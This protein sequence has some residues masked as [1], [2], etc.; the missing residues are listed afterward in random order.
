MSGSRW[1]LALVLSTALSENAFGLEVDPTDAAA[2]RKIAYE[3]QAAY[4]A[5]D[6][7]AAR[8]RASVA[9]R[10]V[11]VPTLALLEGRALLRLD[12][13]LE[14]RECFRAAAAP[15]GGDAPAA[16]ERAR[17]EAKQALGK[18]ERDLPRIVLAIEPASTLP[19][20]IALRLDGQQVSASLLG[21]ATPQNPGR[22]RLTY[23]ISGQTEK[24]E[25]ELEPREVERLVIELPFAGGRA[26]ARG[27]DGRQ[28]DGRWKPYVAWSA[29]GLGGLGLATG[30]VMSERA[31]SI[32]EDLDSQCA[33]GECPPE[34]RDD[35]GRYKTARDASTIAY[36]AGFAAAASGAVLLWQLSSESTSADVTLSLG[37]VQLKGKF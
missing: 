9:Y 25:F 23:R 13:W 17:R 10:L 3:A 7:E 2:A 28:A 11:P 34:A 37:R 22:H 6:Y 20:D 4:E 29:V 27:R 35:I 30:V 36:V 26:G 1:A 12:R 18:L 19:E 14:A 31:F 16:F 32:K 21:V 24:R 5:G 8:E 15:L 33:A